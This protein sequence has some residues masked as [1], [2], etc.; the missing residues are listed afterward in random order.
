MTTIFL[1]SSMYTLNYGTVYTP[2]PRTPCTLLS[3]SFVTDNHINRRHNPYSNICITSVTTNGKAIPLQTWTCPSSSRN[4]RLS[5]QSA[6][7]GGKVVSLKHRP[8]LPFPITMLKG[9]AFVIS[10]LCFY[11]ADIEPFRII[12]G[13]KQFNGVEESGGILH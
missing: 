1:G 3:S 10:A 4:L 12:R 8:P 9:L 6:N 13:F 5:R 2:S 7:E 11:E